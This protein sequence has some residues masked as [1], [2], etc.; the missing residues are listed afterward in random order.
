MNWPPFFR[1]ADVDALFG[2]VQEA[3]VTST[4]WQFRECENMGDDRFLS[5]DYV[6]DQFAGENLGFALCSFDHDPSK[7]QLTM[8]AVRWEGDRSHATDAEYMAA[9]RMTRPVFR[10]AA[11]LLKQPVRLSHPRRR[12]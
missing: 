6:G 7:V 12:K 3:L 2:A 4:A 5:A 1:F 10:K 8:H 9:E 11:R